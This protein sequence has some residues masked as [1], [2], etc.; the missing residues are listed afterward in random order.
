MSA[1]APSNDS[2]RHLLRRLAFA[3][4]TSLEQPLRD[5]TPDEAFNRLW[6]S[7]LRAPVRA[8]PDFLPTRWENSALAWRGQSLSER[9]AKRQEQQQEHAAQT[10]QL[11]A[12]WIVSLAQEGAPLR[13]NLT[14]FLH[15]IFGSSTSSVEI[16]QALHARNVL[17]WQ[18]CMGTIPQLLEQLILDPAMMMQIGMD[19][20]SFERVSDRPAKLVLDHWTVGAGEYADRDVEELSRALT[21]WSLGSAT[22]EASTAELDP[23]APLFSRRLGIEPHFDLSAFDNE[24][25]TLLGVTANFDARS[26]L[27]HLAMQPATA[28]RFSRKLLRHL[29][30]VDPH[31]ALGPRLEQVYLASEG[32]MH[33]LLSSIVG[34]EEFWSQQTRWSLIKSPAHLAA[35]ACRQLLLPALPAGELDQWMMACGQTLFDT[36]NNGEGGWTGQEAWITPPDRLALRYQLGPLLAGVLGRASGARTRPEQWLLRLDPAPGLGSSDLRGIRTADTV[37]TLISAPQYQLA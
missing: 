28:R 8:W 24:P 36:P 31:D 29:G 1:P 5:L 32:S 6:E 27:R 22:G 21:G 18:L 19:G 11:R 15:G 7:S 9:E 30:V 13:E 34:A 35:G 20:H 23:A 3:A 10:A 16:P 2:L 26:A 33:A 4:T 25:K 14:L 17:L 12:S 37:A